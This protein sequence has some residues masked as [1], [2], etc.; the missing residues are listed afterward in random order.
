MSVEVLQSLLN[1]ANKRIAELAAEAKNA[2]LK[3]KGYREEATT[4][5]S[6]LKE[7][8]AAI[9]ALTGERDGLQAK[10]TSS[11]SEIQKELDTLK[12][13]IRLGKHK[14]VFAQVAKDLKVRDEAVDD[15]F[16]LSGYKAEADLADPEAIKGMISPLLETRSYLLAQDPAPAAPAKLPPGPGAQRGAPSRVAGVERVDH[17]RASELMATPAGAKA[18]YDG[19]AA[20]S[21]ELV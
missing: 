10:L 6:K 8:E 18:L 19:V 9:Q 16:N 14:S 4:A 21:I 12:G 3:A 20:G 11:P 15:L 17:A 1:D 13:E 5:A 2:R 7:H